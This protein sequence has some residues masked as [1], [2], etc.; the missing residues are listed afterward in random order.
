MSHLERENVAEMTWML[1]LSPLLGVKE[2]YMKDVLVN[3]SQ[4]PCRQLVSSTLIQDNPL[5]VDH[6]ICLL[7]FR[8]TDCP[9]A[10]VAL[11]LN[12]RTCYVTVARQYFENERNSVH[13]HGDYFCNLIQDLL[14]LVLLEES[15]TYNS[16][17]VYLATVP[18]RR[19]K[20]N[21]P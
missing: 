20:A 8:I 5:L 17:S 18:D 16:A 9:K 2:K 3:A 12:R 19:S 21:H 7:Q 6:H 13:R 14:W 11:F 4:A 15:S 10:S 1:E